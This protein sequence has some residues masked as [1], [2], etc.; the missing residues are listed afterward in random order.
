MGSFDHHVPLGGAAPVALHHDARVLV[1]VLEVVEPGEVREGAL[2]RGDLLEGREHERLA[3]PTLQAGHRQVGHRHR[4]ARHVDEPAHVLARGQP[5]GD[6]D[7]GLL[8]LAV[9]EQVGA[10]VDEHRGSN[11]VVPVVVM[12]DAPERGFHPADHDR[13]RRPEGPSRQPG[14]DRHRPVGAPAR[15]SSRSVGVVGPGPLV[16]R[17]VVDERVHRTRGD[18]H[19]Q[20]R[21]PQAKQVLRRVPARLGHDS[22]PEAPRLEHPA[23]DRGP[24]GGVVHVGVARDEEDVDPV[25]ASGGD[26]VWEHGQEPAGRI[27]GTYMSPRGPAIKRPRLFDRWPSGGMIRQSSRHPRP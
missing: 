1:V 19:E 17:V 12:G 16:G 6:L 20:A 2:V 15:L 21:T 7:D 23:D 25:P 5:P 10:A 26:L 27:H 8:P 24:E 4:R 18:P 22:H 13:H 11:P 14:V 3:R 9:D